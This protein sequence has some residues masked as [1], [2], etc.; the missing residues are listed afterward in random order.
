MIVRYSLFIALFVLFIFEGTFY[1]AFAPDFYGFPYELI[2]RG[3]FMLIL[4]TGIYRGRGYG[5]LYGIFFGILYDIVYSSVLGVYTFGMGL[6]AYVL[7]IPLPFIKN[8]LALTILTVISG[9]ALLEYYIFGMMI[10]LGITDLSNDIFLTVRF[11]PTLIMN[12]IILTLIAYPVKL[13]CQKVDSEI[14]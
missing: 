8:N 10:L 12:F 7:S 3:M 11:I 5:L 14:Q 2:P 1:Q 4:L 6:I 9:V 13:W